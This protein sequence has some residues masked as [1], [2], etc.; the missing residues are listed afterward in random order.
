MNLDEIVVVVKH[1]DRRCSPLCYPNL[2]LSSTLHLL[3]SPLADST[4][5][6]YSEYF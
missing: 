5:F 1:M 4:Y 6:I 2:S 3:M